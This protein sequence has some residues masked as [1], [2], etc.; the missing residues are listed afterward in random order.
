MVTAKAKKLFVVIAYDVSSTRKRSKIAKLLEACGRRVNRSVFECM[1]SK[2]QFAKIRNTIEALVNKKTDS[3]VYYTL[4]V[5][6]YCN[7]NR[8]PENEYEANEI[9]VV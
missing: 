7:I 4:C 6:C 9:V 3:V 2:S 8:Y 5:N 1:L